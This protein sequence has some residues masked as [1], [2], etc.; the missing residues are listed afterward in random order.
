MH[1]TNLTV[2]TVYTV[3]HIPGPKIVHLITKIN[4]NGWVDKVRTFVLYYK[5]Q[6]LCW[7]DLD[8]ERFLTDKEAVI[9]TDGEKKYK[10][11]QQIDFEKGHVFDRIGNAKF[12]KCH[13][14]GVQEFRAGKWEEDEY[15]DG[16]WE[17]DEYGFLDKLYKDGWREFGCYLHCPKCYPKEV[18][19][20]ER[21]N[22]KEFKK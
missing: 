13:K 16:R 19:K 11:L 17:I 22:K 2:G 12:V 8:K 9:I 10:E 1:Y 18:K 14:C 15:H 20:R 21:Y 5:D 4:K 6:K 7:Y 3:S